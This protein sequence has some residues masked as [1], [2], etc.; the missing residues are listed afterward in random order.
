[1]NALSYASETLV[2]LKLFSNSV[3]WPNPNH[4]GS[5]LDLSSF[6]ALKTVETGA[7]FFCLPLEYGKVRDGLYELLPR[8][9][10]S[11]KVS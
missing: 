2:H 3:T 1:M 9:I 5:R 8:N 11:L 10:V 7:E 6:T 4:D